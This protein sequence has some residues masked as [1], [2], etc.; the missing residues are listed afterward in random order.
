MSAAI[1]E[2]SELQTLLSRSGG[3]LKQFGF[4]TLWTPDDR[5]TRTPA[6]SR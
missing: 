3:H 2:Q 4:V 6:A 1:H 5:S